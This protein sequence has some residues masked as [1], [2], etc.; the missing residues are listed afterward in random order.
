MQENL[1]IDEKT[2]EILQKLKKK[3][4]TMGQDMQSYLDGLLHADFITYWDY[5]HLDTLLSLQNPK[6][7]F[8][9]EVIFITY[10]QITELYFK[11]ILW[12]LKQICDSKEMPPIATI[13]EKLSRINRYFENLCYSFDIMTEGLDKDQFLKFRM[14]LLPSS[15]FQSAQY[16]YIEF[17]STDV[18]YL[19]DYSTNEHLSEDSPIEK[20]MDNLYWKQGA[21]ELS[22]GKKTL[23]LKQFEA[24]YQASFIEKARE[25]KEQNLN[26]QMLKLKQMNSLDEDLVSLLKNYD[27]L[28]NIHWPLAHYKSA[29]RYLHKDPK[30]IAATGGTN[31]QKYL[32]PRFQKIVF[33]PWLWSK[34][35][36]ENWGRNWVQQNIKD[37]NV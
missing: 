8:N 3:Y 30:D 11:L 37:K 24:Q 35:E 33:F 6:T 27:E 7:Q 28:I 26:Q 2:L 10:H 9:D 14:A 18:K 29:A 23:T 22:T 1:N 25:L 36:L 31:W 5:I 12:E 17:Y 19:I 16:R 34:K 32:P 4:Q 13:K 15:G 21:T 20:L